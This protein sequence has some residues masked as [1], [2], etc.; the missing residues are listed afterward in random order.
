MTRNNESKINYFMVT[1]PSGVVLTSAW[2][3]N[4]GVSAKLAWWYVHSGLLEKLGTNAY[5]KAGT[6]ITWAGAINALQSQ[7]DIPIH[8]GGKTALH[9]LG[10]GHFI[11]M[12]GMQEVM[13]FAPPNTKIPKWLLALQWDAKFELYKSSLFNDAN[14][15]IGF[16]ERS[17]NEINLKLSSPERAAMELLYLYPKHQSFDE[18]AYLIENLGQL[19]PKLVQ[20]L[21]QNCNSIKVKRLFLHLS[22]QFN[23]SW[24]SSLDITKID[25]GKGKRELGDGGK[26]YSK[27]KLSLPEIK[28][29]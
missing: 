2:L 16:I 11:P 5:K 26:Y 12:Q 24:L 3:K 23:H 18:I 15:E 25:L 29:S 28:E 6:R 27:Y 10:L 21:L 22:E 7:L 20:T 17:I 13:L 19:R 4:H 14:N 1:A 9:L 8:V